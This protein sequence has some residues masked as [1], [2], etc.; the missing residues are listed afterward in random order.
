MQMEELRKNPNVKKPVAYNKTTGYNRLIECFDNMMIQQQTI[1]HM[2]KLNT[3]E[4]SK[5]GTLMEKHNDKSGKCENNGC[6]KTKYIE[7][8]S[9]KDEYIERS[10][11]DNALSWC[12]KCSH[13]SWTKP[14]TVEKYDYEGK[15]FT[16]KQSSIY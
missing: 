3:L 2:T 7:V 5:F 9:Q 16:T 13:F 6:E 12:K 8:T 4:L 14:I 11:N 15:Y 10:N 1:K